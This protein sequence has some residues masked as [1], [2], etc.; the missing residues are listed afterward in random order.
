MSGNDYGDI[1]YPEPPKNVP[2]PVALLA[3]VG[4]IS[5]VFWFF[6]LLER[7]GIWMVL[8]LFAAWLVWDLVLKNKLRK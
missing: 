3:F 1:R 4:L 5:C 7:F 8:A 6:D 2:T